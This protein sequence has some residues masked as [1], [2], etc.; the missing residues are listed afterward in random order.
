[1]P[2][3]DTPATETTVELRT[4]DW[5]GRPLAGFAH[6]SWMKRGLPDDAF[7]GKPQIG[8]ASSWSELTPCNS[9][10]HEVAEHV[11]RGVWEAGGVPHIFP[12]TSL[13]E[14]QIRPTAMLLRNLMAMDVEETLRGNP[15]DGVVLLGGCDKTTPAQLMGAASVDMPAIVVSGGPMLSGRYKGRQ[16]GSGTDLWGFID[17]VRAGRMSQDEFLDLESGMTRSRGSCNTMGTASTMACMSEALGIALPHNGAL[18]AADSRRLRLAHLAGR[19]AVE[20]V[21]EGLT[22]SK[23]LT[24]ANFE[25]AIRVLAAIGGSTNAVVHLLA[26]AGRLGVP[27]ELADFDRFSSE[28]PLLVNLKPSGD[29]LMEDFCYSGGLPAVIANMGDII[30][31]DAPTVTGKPFSSYAD[32]DAAEHSDPKVIRSL[33]DPVLADSGIAVLAGNLCPRGAVIKPNAATPELMQHRGRA[34]V[35]ESI[36][37]YH[38]RIDDPELDVDKDC[39]LVLKGCGPKGYPGMPEVGNFGLPQRLLAE[40]VSDMV[41]VSDA[42]MSGTAYG[43]VVLHTAPEAADGGPL[44]LVQDGD[45]IALDVANRSL[46]LEVDDAEMDA[47]RDAW[48]P[49][50]APFDRGYYR[51]YVEHVLQADRGCDFDFLVGASGHKVTRDSH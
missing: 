2:E 16:L 21:N 8:I 30:N 31:G 4:S 25:N 9:H 27:L 42:R 23:V 1:M 46:T 41:R 33:D 3:S 49:P 47:R 36:E 38:E 18:P 5:Y 34:I 35:F 11:K 50:P 29:Y 22:I 44:A 7:E 12:T 10:L 51:L 24:R 13:G 6:R 48:S 39:V 32:A 28:S 17:D 45:M 40:G 43:T 19:R 26:I 15:I 20:M 14:T 37:D